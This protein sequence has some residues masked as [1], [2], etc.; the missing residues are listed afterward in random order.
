MYPKRRKLLSAIEHAI[1][2]CVFQEERQAKRAVDELMHAGFD[3]GQITIAFS[4]EERAIHHILDNLG[5]V[6]MPEEEVKYCEREFQAGHTIVAVRH[7]GRHWETAN[8]LYGNKIYKYWKRLRYQNEASQASPVSNSHIITVAQTGEVET[9]STIP[10]WQKLL[11]DA[12][13]DHLFDQL[14]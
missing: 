5:N 8:I 11:I 1:V 14:P 7:D 4:G 13:L 10:D 12:E 2:V 9:T 3:N 6:E